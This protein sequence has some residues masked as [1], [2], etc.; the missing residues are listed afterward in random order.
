MGTE[1]KDEATGFITRTNEPAP[2]KVS[3][4]DQI[5]AVLIGRFGFISPENQANLDKDFPRPEVQETATPKFGD[6]RH[7]E[8]L[9]AASGRIYREDELQNHSFFMAHKEDILL[10]QREGRVDANFYEPRYR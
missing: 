4:R 2:V 9:P 6:I 8:R 10:A 7:G 1:Y 3:Q 5:E